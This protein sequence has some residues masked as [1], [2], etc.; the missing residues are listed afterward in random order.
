M[1]VLNTYGGETSTLAIIAAIIIGVLALFFLIAAFILAEPGVLV[2]A[3]VLGVLAMIGWANAS[4]PF[5]HEVTLRPGGVI[6][7]VKYD[8]IEQRGAIYV[9]EERE[10]IAE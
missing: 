3:G 4:E 1:D 7:A 6:D 10:A 8:I 2:I 5:R 9:I